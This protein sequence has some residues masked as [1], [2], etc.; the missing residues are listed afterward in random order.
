MAI[1]GISG[2]PIVGGNTDRMIKAL[3][4]GS[5]KETQFVNLSTLTFSPCRGCAHRCA[6]TGMCAEN[7]DLRPW[8]QAVKDADALILGSAVHHSTMTGWMFSLI[9]RLWCFCHT[10]EL[11]RGKPALYVWT[12][13]WD[14]QRQR[15]RGLFDRRRTRKHE[16]NDLGHIYYQSRNAPCL[17]CG[18]GD[19]CRRGGLWEILGCSEQALREFEFTPDKF[20]RWEDN[21]ETVAQVEKY[22]AILADSI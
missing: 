15:D 21:P 14:E 4:S 17:K 6:K 13:L 22:A 1:L 9:T 8:L 11:L 16:F 19:V 18:M 5:G 12:G 2:S 7:D 10:E 20:H 3:L